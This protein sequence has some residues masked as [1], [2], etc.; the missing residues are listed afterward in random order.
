MKR[1]RKNSGRKGER[2][3]RERIQDSEKKRESGE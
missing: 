2:I 1:G 3:E